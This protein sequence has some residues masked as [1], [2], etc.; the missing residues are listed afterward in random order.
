MGL[1]PIYLRPNNVMGTQISAFD[2]L[3][4]AYVQIASAQFTM[5]YLNNNCLNMDASYTEM[6]ELE[7]R[8]IRL[9]PSEILPDGC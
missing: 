9:E 8:V 1:I 5:H 2:N 6:H 4:M 7:I 3:F